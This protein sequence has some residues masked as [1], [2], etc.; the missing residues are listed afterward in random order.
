MTA[1]SLDVVPNKGVNYGY[2]GEV[3]RLQL[4]RA[5]GLPA[6]IVTVLA[7]TTLGLSATSSSAAPND[8]ITFSSYV[9]S[10]IQTQ[11]LPA[12]TE[13][14]VTLR[15]TYKNTSDTYISELNLD[16]ATF[17]PITTRTQ[18][19]ELLRE[20]ASFNNL[21]ISTTAISARLRNL[22]PGVTKTW[23]VTFRGEQVLGA[24]AAGV[25]AIGLAPQS[26]DN[27]P[28]AAI[29]IPWFFNS[30][31]QPTKVVLAIPLTTLSTNLANGKSSDLTTDLNEADRLSALL[32]SQGNS[33]VSWLVDS[34]ISTWANNLVVNTD[35]AG[36]NELVAA[37]A[38][39]PAG[40][41][42][43]PYGHAD[44]SA[45][46]RGGKQ[47]E[48][49]EII[50]RT[51][52]TA[53]GGPIFYTP[54]S[55]ESDRTTTAQLNQQNIKSIISNDSIHDNERET[56]TASVTSSSNQVLV[57]DV[58]ASKC[59]IDMEA[60]EDSFFRATTCI[61][62]ELGMITAESPQSARSIIVL[63]PANWK[64]SSLGLTELILQLSN[65]N[66]MQLAPLQE[67][68][69]QEATESFIALKPVEARSFSRTLLRLS[70]EVKTKTES[71]SALYDDPELAASFTTARL[72]GYSDL[73]P[74]NAQ[75]TRYFEQNSNLLN[76]YL[77]AIALEA[78]AQITTPQA[79]SQIPITI[80]NAS[81]RDVSVSLELTSTSE[82]RFSAQPSGL[83]QVAP[84]QRVT[85]PVSISLIGAGI[86]TVQAQL[87][88]PNGERFGAGKEI[89]ISSAAYSQF[90]RTLVL[91]AFGL[92]LALALSNFIKRRK[93]SRLAR[94]NQTSIE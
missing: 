54:A 3:N 73:W 26:R 6:I 5:C 1:P 34:A 59:L 11:A 90:A 51:I 27:G 32:R 45:M 48:V 33:A 29:A 76:E 61:K 72:L 40:T 85:V 52:Q 44:L 38:T 92:L 56:T 4:L 14:L 22:A 47:A 83:V 77:D 93:E 66:W 65:H 91:G 28:S 20:P 81:D 89:Q 86:V 15:G 74:S 12:P 57:F 79:N 19:G 21:A 67:I 43:L 9:I 62:A 30:E 80:V 36:A 53:A 78:S 69:A 35:T 37:L 88:A 94:T 2:S 8:P 7:M 50:T 87:I 63:A 60:N 64:V 58:A 23:Q 70:S 82:S 10:P 13:H 41:P 16:L 68:A 46:V 75:A 18:L 55:G 17:G 42:V 25:F 71:V 49:G 31:V 84:G 24:D 39:L